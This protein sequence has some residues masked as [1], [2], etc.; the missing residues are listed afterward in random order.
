MD[1]GLHGANPERFITGKVYDFSTNTS[2]VKNRFS[3]RKKLASQYPSIE[4]EELKDLLPYKSDQMLFT[5]GINEAI[6]LITTMIDSAAIVEP[7]YVEYERALKGNNKRIEHIRTIEEI[8]DVDAVFLCNPNNPD[9]RVRDLKPWVEHCQKKDILLIVDESYKDF[10]DYLETE[11]TSN[12]VFLRSL[13]K[14]YHMAGLR[15][16]YVLADKRF[17]QQLHKRKPTWSVNA[18]AQH[19]GRQLLKD[20][21]LVPKTRRFYQ[22]ES[23]WFKQQV[24]HL[25]CTIIDYGMHYFLIEVEDDQLIIEHMLKN[26]ILVR[27]TRNFKHLKGRFIRVATRTR[28]ENKY[29]IKKLREIL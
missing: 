8:Q 9:G 21:T 16:G 14:I 23:V 4:S 20:K 27:H 29:F 19:V 7:T 6:Y 13:T 5:N 18:Y 22:K 15:L 1:F 26:R 17:I 10:Y 3:I 25:G 2:V 11:V 24:Q 28:R 12:V